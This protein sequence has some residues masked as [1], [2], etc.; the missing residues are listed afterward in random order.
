MKLND[1]DIKNIEDQFRRAAD[2]DHVLDE[3]ILQELLKGVQR[4]EVGLDQFS[5]I[6]QMSNS[7]GEANAF[8]GVFVGCVI[9]VEL[10]TGGTQTATMFLKK[11]MS[12]IVPN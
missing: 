3:E 11:I 5:L 8:F 9:M 12:R 6:L 10:T 2:K 7:I 4:A 1:T